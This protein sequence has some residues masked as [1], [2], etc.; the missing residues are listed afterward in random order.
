MTAP[1]PSR[2]LYLKMRSRT[3]LLLTSLRLF[4]LLLR[5]NGRVLVSERDS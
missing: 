2:S 3:T 1:G 5:P 4:S